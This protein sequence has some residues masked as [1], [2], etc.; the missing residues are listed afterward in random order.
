ML[1]RLWVNLMACFGSVRNFPEIVSGLKSNLLGLPAIKSL[2][3][4]KQ[5][6]LVSSLAQRMRKKFPEV[7]Y[8]LKTLGSLHTIKLKEG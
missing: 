6:Y 2:Q 7:F 3:L 4:L 8:G 5:V 1:I